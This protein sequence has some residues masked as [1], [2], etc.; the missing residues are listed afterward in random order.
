VRFPRRQ[1]PPPS[2]PL[3]VAL[4]L[5]LANKAARSLKQAPSLGGRSR[6][7]MAGAAGAAS[8]T[9]LSAFVSSR[10]QQGR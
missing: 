9:A 2:R 6:A 5:A 10:R 4:A 7:A 3:M 1:P 8:L